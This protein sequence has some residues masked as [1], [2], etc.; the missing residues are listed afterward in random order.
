M[1]MVGG[2]QGNDTFAAGVENVFFFSWWQQQS[3]Y[4]SLCHAS[5]RKAEKA[6][7]LSALKPLRISVKCADW[8]AAAQRPGF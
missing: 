7:S 4:Y 2:F 5:L 3:D 8:S 1:K 6:Y